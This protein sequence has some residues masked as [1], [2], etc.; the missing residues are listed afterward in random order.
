[1]KTILVDDER[2]GLERFE[3]ECGE[4]E[5]IELVGKFRNPLDALEFA[6][7]N[8]VDLAL[9][10]VEMPGM[11]GLDLS[12]QLRILYP[13]LIV[14]F[15][16]AYD[17]YMPDAFRRRG[18]DYYIVKPYTK[19]DVKAVFKRA[20]LLSRRF[21]K[22]IYIET[23]G[24]FCVNVDGKPVR[25]T[26]DDAKELLALMVNKHG[27]PLG[28]QEAFNIMWADRNY[29]HSTAV[30]LHKALRKLRDTLKDAGISELVIDVPPS[31]HKVNTELFD[32][33]YYQLLAGDAEAA[34][35]FHGEY[36]AEWTWGEE[37]VG[38][39]LFREEK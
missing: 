32:C 16:S 4:I 30:S 2:Y 13:D 23:F 37:V 9:L 39:I 34:R 14:I 28:N 6:K 15:V 18:A 22:R 27:T 29:A 8:Q 20:K 33:D 17:E 11:N 35:K 5:G 3:I 26:S 36:M 25:F 24:R 38:D 21:A 10:D 31:A 19:E 12:D 1:M 7:G